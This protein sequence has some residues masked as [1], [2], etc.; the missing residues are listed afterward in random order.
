MRKILFIAFLSI[1]TLSVSA[2]DNLSGIWKTDK[3]NTLVKI[4]KQQNVFIGK[5]ISSDDKESKPGTLVIKDLKE[6]KGKLKGKIYVVSRDQWF[7]GTFQATD[8]TLKI[9]V[10]LAFISKTVEWTKTK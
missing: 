8:K 3:D 1:T 7:N 4:E 2:Q 5:V 9:A 10:S 6:E